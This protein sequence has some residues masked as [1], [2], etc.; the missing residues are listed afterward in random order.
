MGSGVSSVCGKNGATVAVATVELDPSTG[1]TLPCQE[2]RRRAPP[3]TIL[4]P[5]SS[6]RDQTN[7]SVAGSQNRL[8]HNT[9]P[10]GQEDQH[11]D[12]LNVLTRDNDQSSGP[13]IGQ[14][15]DKDDGELDRFAAA[16]DFLPDMPPYSGRSGQS[17]DGLAAD[18]NAEM[19]AHTALSLG[20]DNEDLLFNLMYF[21]AEAAN[22]ASSFGAMMNSVQEE[23][24]ALHSENNT[25]YKLKP[26]TESAIDGLCHKH[27][28]G[29]EVS[30]AP[31]GPSG[32]CECGICKDDID[33]GNPIILLPVC[34]HFFHEECLL[35]WIHLQA[36]CP[37]CRAPVEAATS[38]AGGVGAAGV[39]VGVV[40]DD[41]G[42]GA[43]AG[44]AEVSSS[45]DGHGDIASAAVSHNTSVDM[46]V[47]ATIADREV[48]DA[49]ATSSQNLNEDGG[50]DR[51][52]APTFPAATHTTSAE[53]NQ[54]ESLCVNAVTT[55]TTTVP[56]TTAATTS[57]AAA[58]AVDVR[59]CPY[60]D[61]GK[62]HDSPYTTI[63][64]FKMT[65]DMLAVGTASTSNTESNKKG[66][67]G[68]K[69]TTKSEL[70]EQ[71]YQ[72]Q[73]YEFHQQYV[74]LKMLYDGEEGELDVD[75]AAASSPTA[76]RSAGAAA[77]ADSETYAADAK[78]LSPNIA[79]TLRFDEYY[80]GDKKAS[81]ASIPTNA[82]VPTAGSS[83]HHEFKGEDQGTAP[84][85]SDISTK[86]PI[87]TAMDKFEYGHQNDPNGDFCTGNPARNMDLKYDEGKES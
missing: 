13:D 21:E 68:L 50:V 79:K 66:K 30:A 3:R 47:R 75:T 12:L 80:E 32:A 44:D 26:A 78:I 84:A 40:G 87:L 2:I 22:Q 6:V 43:G 10:V 85:P 76:A 15:L 65:P 25:P 49:T 42:A 39:G 74:P 54:P 63:E 17:D 61:D 4:P 57:T 37:V 62:N 73:Q 77:A 35:R 55:S 34:Q 1:S 16:D 33:L 70:S 19:F 28:D 29:N 36:W 81:T 48:H 56:G 5:S 58:A 72:Q 20:M 60:E 53:P 64:G 8:I 83:N 11:N 45:R 71:M 67:S 82:D 41:T 23:T 46:D 69:G 86:E 59:Y 27:Y 7:T 9:A 18:I 38:A 51:L 24:L 52:V 14:I 31:L